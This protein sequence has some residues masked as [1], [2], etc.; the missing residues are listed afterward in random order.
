MSETWQGGLTGSIRRRNAESATKNC[1]VSLL[2]MGIKTE[3]RPQNDSATEL[4]M[5]LG[6]GFGGEETSEDL[7]FT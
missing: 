1:I 2:R 4:G 6:I 7:K 5:K 3:E